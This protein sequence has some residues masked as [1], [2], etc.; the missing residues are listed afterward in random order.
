M[1]QLDRHAPLECGVGL[2]EKYQIGVIANQSAGTEARLN[3]YGLD[4]FISLCFSSAEIGLTKPDPALFKMALD[5][6][7]CEPC[8]AV[9]VGDRIDNDLRPAKSLGWK[10]VR[11]LQGIARTQTP[12]EPLEEADF[13]I[14][15]LTE[16]YGLL[17]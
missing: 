2:S 10:T 14:G 11:V 16:L 13:T 12:R 5:Q 9:M 1:E 7:G 3:Q 17:E 4:P 8:E 6:A 15:N